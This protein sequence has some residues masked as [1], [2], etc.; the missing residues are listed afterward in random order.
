MRQASIRAA[1]LVVLLVAL[2][3]PSRAFARG[4]TEVSDIVGEQRCRRFGSL[5][6]IE[7]TVPIFF[8]FGMRYSELSTADTTFTEQINKQHRPDGYQPFRYPG[9][10]L[11]VKSLSGLG[12][13]G[14]F[15]FFL[16]GQLYAGFEGAFTFG[17]ATTA[18]FTT[19]SGVKLGNDTGL[20]V[21]IFHGGIPIDYRI[22]L[23]RAALRSEVLMG[24]ADTTVSHHV[25]SP[26]LP[27]TVTAD[28]MRIL[29]E[30]RIAAEIWFTQHI[31]F[32]AYGGMNVL[33]FDGR[34]RSLGV[35]LSWH[36]RSFD[37]DTSF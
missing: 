37:G 36:F 15:G 35:S 24:I 21:N 11:G 2:C 32:A 16:Y 7:G 20:D 4:C 23:G 9:E 25:D 13:E 12:I 1:F 33:D 17:S 31:A 30:P 34:S 5:W 26:G 18:S 10:A 14:G 29:I 28:E 3:V 6:S 27:S 22:P 8:R 19:S